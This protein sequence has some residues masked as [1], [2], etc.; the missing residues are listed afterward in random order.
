ME[1]TDPE[2]LTDATWALSYLSDGDETRIQMV[3]DTGVIP[4]LIKHLE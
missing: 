4:S 3:V 1:E 2:I